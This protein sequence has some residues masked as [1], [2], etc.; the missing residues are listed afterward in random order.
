M[1][2]PRGLLTVT[3]GGKEYR[4]WLGMSVL[5]DL[6]SKH[7]QDVFTKMDPPAGAGAEWLPDLNILIDMFLLA[8]CRY[9]PDADRYLVDEVLAEN[10]D[11]FPKLMAAAF[12]EPDGDKGNARARRAA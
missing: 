12:P 3:A 5:A 2:D 11:V 7:G 1:T 6:Q 10:A 4:L 9:H 8:L